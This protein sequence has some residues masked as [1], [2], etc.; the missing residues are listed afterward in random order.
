MFS[1]YTTN[2]WNRNESYGDYTVYSNYT[3]ITGTETTNHDDQTVY[4]SRRKNGT[5]FIVYV[6]RAVRPVTRNN[7]TICGVV[8]VIQDTVQIYNSYDKWV[9][10]N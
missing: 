4:N 10:P 6:R 2:D 1:N 9:F 5:D 7:V 8:D 3:R